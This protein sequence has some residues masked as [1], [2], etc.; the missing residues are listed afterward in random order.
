MK[1]GHAIVLALMAM[2]ASA[3]PLFAQK[4]TPPMAQPPRAQPDD[5]VTI[6]IVNTELHTAMQLIG[7]YLDRPLIVSGP[8]GPSITLETPHPIARCD[9]PRLLRSLLDSQNYELVDDSIGN[10]YR[11]RPREPVRP[12]PISPP[13]ASVAPRPQVGS[14]ELFVI[15]LKHARASDVASTINLLFGRGSPDRAFRPDARGPGTIADELRA[16]QIPTLGAGPLPET[17]AG[18][19]GR[20]A[21]L[22]GDLAIVPDTRTNSLLIRANRNDFTLI[23]A[24]VEQV[25]VRPLQVL[26][27]VM[28]VETQTNYSF[29]FGIDGA[30]ASQH[31]KNTQNTTISGATTS[32]IAD[33]I[34][35][36][37]LKLMGASGIDVDATIVAAADRGDVH[38]VSRPTVLAANNEKA[39]VVVGTQRPFV[40]LAR[41]LPTDA[42][43]QDQVVQY[44]DVGTKLTVTP[45]ISIDGSVQLGI[46]QEVSN[47]T[48]ETQFNA[49]VI[50]NRSV[51]TELLVHDGQTIVLGG[52]RDR[53]RDGD[54]GGIPLLSRLPLIGGLFGH[55]TR[56]TT[57]TEL[58]I[59]MT[60]HVIRN[61][62]DA[63]AL[64]DPLRKRADQQKP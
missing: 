55:T 42:G 54:A 3:T 46:V 64:T 50:S 10:V 51:S 21:M 17:V 4:P 48:T 61:D 15:P 32:G 23:Q 53:E 34:G 49:P 27:E 43:E 20:P 29:N 2:G 58:Y 6:R 37:T 62:D 7:P 22:S 13:P 12:A 24:A 39:E 57:E 18:T 45:T 14:P 8:P 33:G 35:G 26:I 25:D 38:I 16:N 47:A 63:S 52:L 56:S 9:V 5:S 1:R 30:V 60:P 36:L 11:V 41:T 31:I 40:Q 28:I 19:A 59:F 44:K